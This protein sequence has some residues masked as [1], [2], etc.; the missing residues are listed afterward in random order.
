MYNVYEMGK[1]FILGVITVGLMSAC[2]HEEEEENSVF[3]CSY[4]VGSSACGGGAIVGGYKQ[5]CVTFNT[6]DFREG[7]DVANH[8]QNV[9]KDGYHSGGSS[10]VVYFDYRNVTQAPG[11][12]PASGSLTSSL[13]PH[14][15]S[16]LTIEARWNEGDMDL[17]VLTPMH[18]SVDSQNPAAG[19]CRF[20]GDDRY[21]LN[22]PVES[23]RCEGAYLDGGYNVILSNHSAAHA[24]VT[25][26]VT[27]NGSVISRQQVQVIPGEAQNIPVSVQ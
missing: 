1:T 18:E 9:Y 21:V 6:A 24:P 16:G 7:Y 27:R 26:T 20:S 19:G 17:A 14:A 15:A 10:C 23:V 25:L 13:Q 11:A 4:E 12:C 3:H 2:F 22:G 5:D 8:C